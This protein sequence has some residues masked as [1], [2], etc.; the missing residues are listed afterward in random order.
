MSE[1]RVVRWG[2]LSTGRIAADF[3]SIQ[4]T[5]YKIGSE[6]QSFL[7]RVQNNIKKYLLIYFNRLLQ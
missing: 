6:A 3:V 2:I 7:G 5:E 4:N 1:T